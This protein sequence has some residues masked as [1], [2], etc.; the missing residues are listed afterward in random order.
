MSRTGEATTPKNSDLEGHLTCPREAA[1]SG[2]LQTHY[3][4]EPKPARKVLALGV[5]L[6]LLLLPQSL[7][8]IGVRSAS[9][10]QNA[11]QRSYE[12]KYEGCGAE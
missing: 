1:T 9:S 4:A 6:L 3:S 11:G 2:S 7:E 12:Q 5:W 8:R 10:R